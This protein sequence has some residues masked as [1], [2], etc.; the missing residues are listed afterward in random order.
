MGKLSLGELVDIQVGYAF[1]AG[2]E[3]DRNAPTGVVQMKDLVGDGLVDLSSLDRVWLDAPAAR[4]L[5]EKDVVL[6]SRGDRTT[7]VILAADPGVAILAAPLLRLRVRD[8][9]LLPEFLHW[10]VNQSGAQA[11]LTRRNE[12]SS[13]KMLRREAV[14]ELQIDLPPLERQSTIVELARLAQRDL[15]LCTRIHSA[16]GRLLADV[17]TR[18]AEESE[19]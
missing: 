15:Q 7:A 5:V 6:R 18:Y 17:M 11:H 2:L 14:E 8:D 19:A 13:V 1:R 10:A 4:R 12:G 16:R 3:P 9:R